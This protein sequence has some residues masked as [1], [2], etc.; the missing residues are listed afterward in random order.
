MHLNFEPERANIEA[1]SIPKNL[2]QVRRVCQES[3]FLLK[4]DEKSAPK[5]LKSELFLYAMLQLNGSFEMNDGYTQQCI[6]SFKEMMAWEQ[7]VVE[8]TN[9]MYLELIPGMPDSIDTLAYALDK[10]H[11]L[12]VIK[13]GYRYV[14]DGKTVELFYKIRSGYGVKMEWLHIMSGS[15][16][17]IEDYLHVFLKKYKNTIVRSLL[18]NMMTLGNV[19]SIIGCKKWWKSH[20]YVVWMLSAIIT[21]QC[22]K[23]IDCMRNEKLSQEC[24]DNFLTKLKSMRTIFK[25]LS[26]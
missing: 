18:S 20:N 11:E 13:L 5:Q 23:T 4:H 9:T 2:L 16:H 24:I 14:M 15:W 7:P 8:K 12:F 10:I 25:K 26:N 22:E 17:L 1:C 3:D 21:E 6:P 19:N